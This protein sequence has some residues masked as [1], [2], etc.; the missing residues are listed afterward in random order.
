M[1]TIAAFPLGDARIERA[2]VDR[3]TGPY[4]YGCRSCGMTWDAP[5]G[6]R[7]GLS[8]RAA[9][10]MSSRNREW[11]ALESARRAA[12]HVE[13]VRAQR[14]QNEAQ[15]AEILTEDADAEDDYATRISDDKPRTNA[16][17][18]ALIRGTDGRPTVTEKAE[19]RNEDV[20][21]AVWRGNGGGR[22]VDSARR[23]TGSTQAGRR[24]ISAHSSAGRGIGTCGEA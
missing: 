21:A 18:L 9:T 2:G 8:S 5:P 12:G 19:R 10:G 13:R 6:R 16:D 7:T 24:G 23:R 22:S 4:S 20:K 3:W 14:D 17:N 1:V 15:V 11:T